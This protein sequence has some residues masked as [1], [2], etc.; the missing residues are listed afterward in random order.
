LLEIQHLQ[1]RKENTV[2][3]ISVPGFLLR[4]LY[5]KGTLRNSG[6]GFLFELKNSL[7]SGYAHKMLPLKLNGT[8]LKIDS[9]YFRLGDQMTQFSKVS[10]QNTF[11]LSM[12]ETIT[13]LHQKQTLENGPQKIEMGFEI[14]GL[15]ILKFDFTDV[16]NVE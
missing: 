5:V 3:V 11:A 2:F 1:D 16:V 7:G 4:H 8:E 12:N 14:P 15:G 13:I 6:D 10:K 9:T